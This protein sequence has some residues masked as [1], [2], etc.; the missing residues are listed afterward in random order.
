MRHAAVFD[1]CLLVWQVWD[2]KKS[3]RRDNMT[4][5][6]FESWI[7]NACRFA[8]T[9]FRG[10]ALTWHLDNASFHKAGSYW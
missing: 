8:K 5:S 2:G 6:R 9:R 10:K 7:E 3:S 4:A 1:E